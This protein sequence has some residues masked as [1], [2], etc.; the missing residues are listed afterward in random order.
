[1]ASE[2]APSIKPVATS[3]VAISQT[4]QPSPPTSI[5]ATNSDAV[6]RAADL[7]D[8]SVHGEW[9]IENIWA[10]QAVGVV[11]APPKCFKT[12]TVLEALVAV[13][14][15]TPF[16]A[17][18]AVHHQGKVL[19]FFAEDAH[20][21]I[22]SR[23]RALCASRNASLDNLDLYIITRA[24]LT[25]DNAFDFKWLEDQ[26][27]AHRPRLLVLDPLVR[28]FTGDED[29]AGSIS[30]VLGLLRKLQR[31]YGVA[32]MLVHHVKKN[33]AMTTG[34][35]LRGSGDLH[36][37]GD[38]NLYLTPSKGGARVTVEHRAARAPEPFRVH[39]ELGE[40]AGTEHLVAD[41]DDV[42]GD[43]DG[44]E[45]DEAVDVEQ[46]IM[47][48][49]NGGPLG[50]G[51]I[52]DRL[53]VRG[54][55]VTEALGRL[56][57]NGQVEKDGRNWRLR[58]VPTSSLRQDAE[59]NGKGRAS[60]AGGNA[61]ESEDDADDGPGTNRRLALDHIH[62]ADCLEIF[63]TLPDNSIDVCLTDPP[64]GLGNRQPTRDDIINYLGGEQLEM[65]GDFMGK[66]WSFPTITVW[67]EIFRV[68]K[69]GAHLFAFASPRTFDLMAL[70]IRAAGF[71]DRDTIARPFGPVST[72]QWMYSTGFPKSLDIAK[73]I[74][75]SLGATPKV[76]RTEQRLNEPNGIVG[77]G[78]GHE[79]R[80]IITRAIT[81][82][83]TEKAKKWAGWGTA[84]KPAWEPITCFR[85]AG[86]GACPPAPKASFFYVAK[87]SVR[88][89]NAGLPTGMRNSHPCVKPVRL[90]RRLLELVATPSDIVLDPYAGSGSTLVAALHEGM[91]FV[92]IEREEEYVKIARARVAFAMACR[93]KTSPRATTTAALNP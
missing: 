29:D 23:V 57:R 44:N 68:L 88:E 21:R 11:G 12:W 30:R 35:S 31:E 19:G 13:A 8:V 79:A 27:R 37:W 9:L 1:M 14:T 42:E 87:A 84:L 74:D 73:A 80:K 50:H 20:E 66:R 67:K 53:N 36:A 16:L 25:L 18:H 78:R 48:I 15:G 54:S 76:V 55:R 33:T 34:A 64:Y 6:V 47:T 7:P 86:G 92:G 10:A 45:D 39:L 71:D 62:R 72:L 49:L 38:S 61:S 83:V 17:I 22:K 81:E 60:G 93:P 40:G 89:R 52:R 91:R 63:R 58:S 69:P 75:K 28:I 77:A 43:G 41:E 24:R 85:K 59:R 3:I 70:G 32:I 82:P 51:K 5:S 26:V 65:G 4:V 2:S 56:Q 90:L 46:A